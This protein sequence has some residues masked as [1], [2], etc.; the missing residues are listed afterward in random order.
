MDLLW[1]IENQI[2]EKSQNL[3]FRENLQIYLSN[4]I[5]IMKLIY[6]YKSNNQRIPKS[7][8]SS[9]SNFYFGSN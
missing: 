6:Q 7:L 3:H 9:N 5:Q 2:S 1:I 8:K 4:D